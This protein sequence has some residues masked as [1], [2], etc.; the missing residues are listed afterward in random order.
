MRVNGT[1]VPRELAE[2]S[3]GR[4]LL[5]FLREDRGLTGAKEG[6]GMGECGSCTVLV[7]GRSVCSCLVLVGQVLDRDVQTVEGLAEHGADLQRAF[8]DHQAVQCGYCIPGVLMSCHALLSRREQP[9]EE[10]V[11]GAL[12]GNL[13]RCTGYRRFVDAVDATA[14]GRR[15]TTAA[16]GPA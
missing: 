2:A 6:C 12:S 9:S 15:D 13:C 14:R 7:D 1:A 11:A 5:D 10:E 8:V 3:T 16:G 4:R